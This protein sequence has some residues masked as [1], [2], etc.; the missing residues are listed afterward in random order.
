[1]TVSKHHPNIQ[2][3]RL[4]SGEPSVEKEH[5]LYRDNAANDVLEIRHRNE[6]KEKFETTDCTGSPAILTEIVL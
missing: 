2:R 1:M 4:H 3:Q 6:K 5:I